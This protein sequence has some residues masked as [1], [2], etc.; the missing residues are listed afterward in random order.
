MATTTHIKVRDARDR[1]IELLG[2]GQ[3]YPLRDLA[4]RDEQLTAPP[5]TPAKIPI[6]NS[7]KGVLYQLHDD[8]ELVE[9]TPE[10]AKGSGVPIK[11]QGNG[12]TLFLKTYKIQEDITFEIHATKQLSG[13]EAYLHQTATVKVGI[14]TTLRAWMRNVPYL[15]AAIENPTDDTPRIVDYGEIVEVE[16]EKSQ[17]GVDYRLVYFKEAKSGQASE[18]VE[19][20]GPLRF[21]TDARFSDQL[22]QQEFPNDLRQVFED[23]NISLSENVSVLVEARNSVWLITDVGNRQAYAIRLKEDKL[24]IYSV[25]GVRGNLDNIIL[26][27]QPVYEDTNIRVR[28]V[29]TFDPSEKR[30]TQTDLLDAVLPLKVRPNPALQVSVAPATIIDFKQPVAIK[31]A[32]TQASAKYQLYIRT[33]PDRDFIHKVVPD[34]DV[35]KEADV[36]V[37]KPA[38]GAVWTLPEGYAAC[39][40]LNRE[41]VVSF[42]SISNR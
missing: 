12:E 20:S 1:L 38:R 14:D 23:N 26:S 2:L 30:D 6:E 42:C 17:E 13:K 31:I 28:A 10:G 19:L 41:L 39:G 5:N 18:E 3:P 21:Q 9:R 32:D 27:T 33:I 22:D 16:I 11:A 37:P 40:M 36:Q 15:D 25:A 34:T 29:K 7:Q 24:D 35:I 4:V 8:H